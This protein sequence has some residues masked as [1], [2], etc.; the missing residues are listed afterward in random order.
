M[1]WKVKNLLIVPR[2]NCVHRKIVFC[3]TSD[4]LCSYVNFNCT[5]V[6]RRHVN[7]SMHFIFLLLGPM[8]RASVY[9]DKYGNWAGL[10]E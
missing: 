6:V 10:N 5:G 1:L 2:I 3:Y 4:F 9:A 8:I 7:R